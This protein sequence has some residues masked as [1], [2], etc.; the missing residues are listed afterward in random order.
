MAD[1]YVGYWEKFDS[2]IYKNRNELIPELNKDKNLILVSH[3][4]DKY[5]YWHGIVQMNESAPKS[6][7]KFLESENSYEDYKT[8]KMLVIKSKD[9]IDI[10]DEY[11]VT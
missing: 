7:C 5:C 6:E 9:D 8:L 11:R 4:D 1:D 10:G 3:R 2:A